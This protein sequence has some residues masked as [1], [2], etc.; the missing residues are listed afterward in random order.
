MNHNFAKWFGNSRV[1][2]EAGNPLVVYHGTAL[3]AWEAGRTSFSTFNGM[4]EGAYFT[5]RA[6]DAAMYAEMD[7]EVEGD[8]Q[9][10]I[11]VFLAIQSPKIICDSIDMQEIT[12]AQRAE[13]E[14]Q[15]HDGMMGYWNGELREIAVWDPTKIKAAHGN[16]GAFDPTDPDITDRRA[17]RAVEALEMLRSVSKKV[18]PS[19]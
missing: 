7:S 2:D 1:V 13:W 5:P 4:G 10:L 15:G 9:F 6:A 12:L 17:A 8:P 14:S 19:G 3:P 11:P 18:S 16:S